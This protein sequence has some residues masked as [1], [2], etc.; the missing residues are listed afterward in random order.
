VK[1]KTLLLLALCVGATCFSASPFGIAEASDPYLFDLLTKST[2]RKSW[3]E[4]F[5]G[6][7]NVDRWLAQY[8]KT[9]DGP[10]TPAKLLE[11]GGVSYQ[12]TSVCKTHD[13]GDNI[14]F[15][16]FASNGAKAWGL[17]LKYQKDE[18]FFGN[19]DESM[20]QLL[21]GAPKVH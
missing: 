11:S 15:V 2:Y 9:N 4:L 17:L 8:A 10:A 1:F 19:P 20:K 12:L 5:R 3:D 13:C 7:K 21:R 6:E 14:F 16:I 18:R